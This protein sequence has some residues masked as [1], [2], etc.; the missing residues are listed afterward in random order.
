MSSSSS[1]VYVCAPGQST[2]QHP[3]DAFLNA[4]AMASVLVHL[5]YGSLENVGDVFFCSS[6]EMN[7]VSGG[8]NLD[9]SRMLIYSPAS[10]YDYR[11]GYDTGTWQI[12]SDNQVSKQK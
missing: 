9:H 12:P 8:L 3:G 2:D 5:C 11:Q 10:V 7:W 1:S 4:A 6:G